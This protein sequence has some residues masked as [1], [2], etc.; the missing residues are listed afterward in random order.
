MMALIE[1]SGKRKAKA[2]AMETYH[3]VLELDAQQFALLLRLLVG[4]GM[5][6]KRHEI[7][8][9]HEA[10]IDNVTAAIL[11]VMYTFSG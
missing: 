8:E 6:D 11:Q 1:Y 2:K 3:G 7:I 5:L 9:H 4:L 10:H